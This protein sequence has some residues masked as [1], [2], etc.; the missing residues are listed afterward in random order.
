VFLQ[1]FDA[2]GWVATGR[3][4]IQPVKNGVVGCWHKTVLCVLCS[5]FHM[6]TTTGCLQLWKTWKSQGMC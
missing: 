4:G 3:K 6:Q 2:V 5:F 1:C